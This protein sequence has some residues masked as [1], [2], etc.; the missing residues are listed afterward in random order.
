MDTARSSQSVPS[1]VLMNADQYWLEGARAC[2][3]EMMPV[4]QIRTCSRLSELKKILQSGNVTGVMTTLTGQG[5]SLT[6]WFVFNR[7]YMTLDQA[8]RPGLICLT[9]FNVAALP[10]VEH[11]RRAS[12]GMR[13]AELAASLTRLQSGRAPA[14]DGAKR[15]Q[16]TTKELQIVDLLAMGISGNDIAKEFNIPV[17]QLGT[18]KWR[19]LSLLGMNSIAEYINLR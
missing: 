19:A 17:G 12:A 1:V 4:I 7:W 10:G 8:Q 15:R 11:V 2:I 13:V 16:L 3:A 9:D 18:Y 14:A 5:E 6:D